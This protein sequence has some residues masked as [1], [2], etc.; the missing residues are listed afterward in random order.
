[1][2]PVL[3]AAQLEAIRTQVE[4]YFGLD[5]LMQDAFLLSRMNSRMMVPLS[6]IFSFKKVRLLSTNFDSVLAAVQQ[7]PSKLVIELDSTDGEWWIGPD[8]QA[9]PNSGCTILLSE[10]S[11][12][13]SVED[14]ES[15]TEAPL[16]HSYN[17]ANG[18][19]FATYQDRQAAK[20]ALADMQ[21]KCIKGVPV[22]AS[23]NIS[24]ASSETNA[25]PSS[26]LNKNAEPYLV[27]SGMRNMVN[28]PTSRT[29]KWLSNPKASPVAG[30]PLYVSRPYAN[31]RTEGM[32]QQRGNISPM[33][34][35]HSMSPVQQQMF[36]M[37]MMMQRMQGNGRKQGDG[38]VPPFQLNDPN[39]RPPTQNKSRSNLAPIG[40][41][42]DETE[43]RRKLQQPYRKLN[44]SHSNPQPAARM[45]ALGADIPVE[46]NREKVDGRK[47]DNGNISLPVMNQSNFPGLTNEPLATAESKPLAGWAAIAKSKPTAIEAP[48]E[49][50]LA[51]EKPSSKKASTNPVDQPVAQNAQMDNPKAS[52]ALKEHRTPTPEPPH[53]APAAT[54]E[55]ARVV[56]APRTYASMFAKKAVATR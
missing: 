47:P 29:A 5:N 53:N 27:P 18:T 46:E 15:L 19:W 20:S 21:G 26:T 55:E 51:K 37:N 49:K 45:E 33:A 6:T 54:P 3:N 40:D 16:L 52:A 17:F 25:A 38:F 39:A 12:D 32:D 9:K 42:V 2:P 24:P 4:F 36:M 43:T 7:L 23:I 35:F 50:P 14:I 34:T 11:E 31:Q 10:V 8:P 44:G 30:C 56:E 22:K 41:D 48:K 13:T 28:M 1:M